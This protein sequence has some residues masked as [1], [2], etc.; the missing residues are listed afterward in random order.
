[1]SV[2]N[3]LLVACRLG[4]IDAVDSFLS[5]PNLNINQ[6]DE[7]NYS[8]LILASICGHYDIVDLLL[9]RG[10]VCDRDTFEGERCIYGALNDQI[11]DLLLSYDLSKKIDI[12]QPFAMHI[13]F[14]LTPINELVTKDLIIEKNHDQKPENKD[15]MTNGTLTNYNDSKI[16]SQDSQLHNG[17]HKEEEGLCP[18]FINRFLCAIRSPVLKQLLTTKWKHQSVVCL[19]EDSLHQL[20]PLIDYIYL[21]TDKLLSYPL[22]LLAQLATEYQ[23]GDLQQACGQLNSAVSKNKDLKLISKLKHDISFELIENSRFQLSQF[24]QSLISNKLTVPLELTDEVEYEDIKADD[25]LSSGYRAQLMSTAVEGLYPDIILSVIDINTESVV[26]YPC[27]ESMLIRS[28]YFDTM[29]NSEIFNLSLN[30]LPLKAYK[31]KLYVDRPNLKGSDLSVI[32]ITCT[33]LKVCELLLSFLYHDDIDHIPLE[34]TIDLLYLADELLLEKLK[35]LCAI[36]I[37]G[38]YKMF[39]WNEFTEIHNNLDNIFKLIRISWDT[40]CDK[41]EQFFTKLIAFNLKQVYHTP[42]LRRQFEEVVVESANRIENR[43]VTD[44]IEL[45]DDI[46]YYLSKKYGVSDE[47]FKDFIPIGPSFTGKFNEDNKIRKDSLLLY[48][49]DIELIDTL[50]DKLNLDA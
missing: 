6:T 4:D 41:L 40:R 5:T 10:A 23:L 12:N 35:T 27:H 31:G 13:S 30:R 28:E 29:F 18:L 34:L 17:D 50:L 16:E 36:N 22:D 8:P 21:K 20:E 3:D 11:R 43:Q 26:Y 45:I 38:K 2:F 15:N 1:M 49:R 7:W 46:R 32:S 14:I 24:L 39:N 48:E 19:E 37:T 9:K 42:D 47:L 44:T 33:N 25:L